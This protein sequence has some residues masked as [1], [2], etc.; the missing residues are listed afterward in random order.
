MAISAT[1][2]ESELQSCI[3]EK[4]LHIM[5]SLIEKL[6]PEASEEDN[7]NSCLIIYDLIEL[8]ESY[9]LVSMKMFIQ[10]IFDKAFP[11]YN[12]S[13]LSSQCASISILTKIV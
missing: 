5:T 1:D 3:K 7:L 9:Q 13:N 6:G 4:Q 8:K 10:E 2:F 11:T 12:E